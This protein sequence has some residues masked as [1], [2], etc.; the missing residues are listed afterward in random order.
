VVV[1]AALALGAYLGAGDDPT[2]AG[3]IA[4][5][6]AAV[7]AAGLVLRRGLLVTAGIALVGAGYGVALV[8]EGLDGAASLFAGGLVLTGELAFWAIEPG[9]AVKV[10]REAT[11]RRAAFAGVVALAGGVLGALLLAAGSSPLEGDSAFGL[12]GAASVLV[13]AATAVWL[14]HSLQND[15]R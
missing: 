5:A 3:L 12:L 7:L 2:E 11:A 6:G 4:L 13:V 8:G 1:A 9:A 14:I 10:G 15:V